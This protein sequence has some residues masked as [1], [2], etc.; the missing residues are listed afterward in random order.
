MFISW[1]EMVEHKGGKLAAE[2]YFSD[3]EVR[4]RRS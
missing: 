2:G 3:F 4:P 1:M